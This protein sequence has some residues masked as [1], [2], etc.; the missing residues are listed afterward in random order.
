VFR[1]EYNDPRI[2]RV[3]EAL[4]AAALAALTAFMDAV[5]FDPVDYGRTPDE[6]LGLAVRRLP[7]G[8]GLGLVTIQVYEPDQL[9]LVL[10]IQW[11]G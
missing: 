10:R 3:V 5:V 6:P 4:P 11:L 1:W 9:V 7:F 8:D 2:Q